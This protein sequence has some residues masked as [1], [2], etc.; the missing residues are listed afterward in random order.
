MIM[1]L[2]H[3]ELIMNVTIACLSLGVS[4]CTQSLLPNQLPIGTPLLRLLWI[5]PPLRQIMQASIL[6]L[7]ELFIKYENREK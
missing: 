5:D 3:I 2:W 7:E 1:Y 4:I 6:N